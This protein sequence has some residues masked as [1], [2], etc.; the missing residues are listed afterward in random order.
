M[1]YLYLIYCLTLSHS[2]AFQMDVS[3]IK[4]QKNIENEI[5]YLD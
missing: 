5:E 3:N 4:C 2:T 1:N